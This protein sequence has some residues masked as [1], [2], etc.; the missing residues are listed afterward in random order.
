MN[1]TRYPKRGL[2]DILTSAIGSTINSTAEA[3][4][5][6]PSDGIRQSVAWMMGDEPPVMPPGPGRAG[7]AGPPRAGPPRGGPAGGRAGG[8]PGQVTPDLPA[9]VIQRGGTAFGWLAPQKDLTTSRPVTFGNNLRGDLYY[10][11]NTPEGAKLPTVVWLHGYSYPL[12][13]MWVY[14]N[15]LHPIL[16]LVRAG[17]ARSAWRAIRA[18]SAAGMGG[19]RAVLRSL[20]ALVPPG[21]TWWKIRARQS[22]RCKRIIWWIRSAFSCSGIRW[23]GWSV[24]TLRHSMGHV[25]GMVSISGFTPMRT[26]IRRLAEPEAWPL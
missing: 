14:H 13:Y 3:G 24:S 1:L 22:M 23:V 20:S 7:R 6:R 26:G 21:R 8:N 18:A 17:Y 11:A 16:A 4:R 12:G 15:D 2:D 19:V 25:Q 9:W 5:R 10:P